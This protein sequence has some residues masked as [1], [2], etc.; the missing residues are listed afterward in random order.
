[1]E[2]ILVPFRSIFQYGLQYMSHHALFLFLCMPLC[3]PIND[4]CAVL[5]QSSICS[6]FVVDSGLDFD[7]DSKIGLYFYA[8]SIFVSTM[9]NIMLHDPIF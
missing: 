1:M 8:P 2:D 6:D 3:L 4:Q 9:E 7:L 5:L